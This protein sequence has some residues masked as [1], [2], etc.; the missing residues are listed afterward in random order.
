MIEDRFFLLKKT[1]NLLAVNSLDNLSRCF[2]VSLLFVVCC[3][4]V[5]KYCT[6]SGGIEVS[7]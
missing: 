4:S 5:F 7:S 2:G 3:I 1:Y 6:S